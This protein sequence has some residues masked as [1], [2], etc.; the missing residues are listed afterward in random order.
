M[1]DRFNF[2]SFK[3]PLRAFTKANPLQTKTE[4]AAAPFNQILPG[5]GQVL[6]ACAD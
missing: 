5:I 3:W 4:A 2:E 6:V 1:N